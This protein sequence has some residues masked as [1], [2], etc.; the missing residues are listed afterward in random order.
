MQNLLSTKTIP[1]MLQQQKVLTFEN[2]LLSTNREGI[3][4]VIEFV[5][6]TDFYT[7][8]ASSKFHSNYPGGLLDHSLSVYA[9]ADKYK[10]VIL[11]EKPELIDKLKD[12]SIIITS[13]LHD[14]CKTCL[15]VQ[16]NKFK[17]DASTGSWVS[18]LGYELNDT[19]PIGHGEKSVI[20]LQNIGLTLYPD[21]M[22]AIRYHMGM[23]DDSNSSLK[24]AQFSASKLTPLVPILQMADFTSSS[25]MEIEN[26]I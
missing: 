7:A 5:K 4:K 13:L 3:D 22:L 23:Y 21:E 9:L 24:Q 18:Y 19:F 11:S 2:L 25:M 1:I 17:K 14:I 20:M 8:P 10:D 16:T 6:G 26:K 15:Y 12:E